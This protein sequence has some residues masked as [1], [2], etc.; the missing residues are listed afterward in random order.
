MAHVTTA[1]GVIVTDQ[2]T[3][4]QRFNAIAKSLNVTLTP[5]NA[6]AGFGPPLH[7]HAHSGG[8]VVEADAPPNTIG[9]KA[10]PPSPKQL[11]AA[12]KPL[13]VRGPRAQG[14]PS[15]ARTAEFHE[16]MRDKGLMARTD[17][18]FLAADEFDREAFEL[19][20]ER[21]KI[22][23][24]GAAKAPEVAARFKAAYEKDVKALYEGLQLSGRQI[25]EL[26]KGLG[27]ADSFLPKSK[28]QPAAPAQTPGWQSHVEDG[29]WVGLEHL[30]TA[31]TSGYTIPQFVSDQ[32]V[33]VSVLEQLKDAKA[34]G[35]TQAQVNAVLTQHARRNGWTKA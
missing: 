11:E 5:V 1:T 33:H 2:M 9:G 17:G 34:A 18:R 26:R 16:E 23:A 19:L 12:N 6:R 35:I 25:T 29:E 15:P 30:T 24:A 31:D 3:P 32:R 28:E 22:L 14:A 8:G 27:K 4:E 13:R 21:Y 10:P 20:T 7:V